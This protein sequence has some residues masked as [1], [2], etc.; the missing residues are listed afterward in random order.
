VA[1]LGLGFALAVLV[2][3]VAGEGGHG[4]TGGG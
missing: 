4:A 3:G 2:G 1:L